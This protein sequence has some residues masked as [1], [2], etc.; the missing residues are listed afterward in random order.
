[1]CE[2]EKGLEEAREI[3]KLWA[4][5]KVDYHIWRVELHRNLTDAAARKR[6][7]RQFKRFEMAGVEFDRGAMN[8]VSCDICDGLG[9]TEEFGPCGSC[10]GDGLVNLGGAWVRVID[11]PE[12]VDIVAQTDDLGPWAFTRRNPPY[13]VCERVYRATK[14]H[15]TTVEGA[16]DELSEA[17]KYDKAGRAIPVWQKAPYDEFCAQFAPELESMK[18]RLENM[19][20]WARDVM[21]HEKLMTGGD[22]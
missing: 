6:W 15:L 3:Q 20:G 5:E 21:A 4:D 9:E 2:I 10:G 1:M 19:L 18:R 11:V 7:E 13:S 17:L 14:F 22:A 16:I 12:S 8:T